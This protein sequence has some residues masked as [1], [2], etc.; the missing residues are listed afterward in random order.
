M[1]ESGRALDLDGEAEFDEAT[2][3]FLSYSKKS[4]DAPL[5]RFRLDRPE[6]SRFRE[7]SIVERR[8]MK[9]FRGARELVELFIDSVDT[10]DS[11][12]ERRLVW[13]LGEKR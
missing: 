8:S 13:R 11:S 10:V 4:G 1:I 12:P 3:F 6:E 5:E 7:D 2:D 9:L